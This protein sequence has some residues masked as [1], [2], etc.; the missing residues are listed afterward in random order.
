M[1][2]LR[3]YQKTALDKLLGG[4]HYLVA[5]CG[6]GKNPISIVWAE[7]TCRKTGKT[8]I[9]VITTASKSRTT[10]H[11]DDLVNFT[12]S[13]GE[14][15]ELTVVSWNSAKRWLEQHLSEIKDYVVVFDEVH[16]A[17]GYNTGMGKVFLKITK[18]NPDWTGYTGT[19]GDNWL[20]FLPYFV[21]TGLEKNKTQYLDKYARVQ[22]F[23]G[24]PEIVG[25]RNTEVLDQHWSDISCSI[26]P[27]EVMA[28][29]KSAVHH[30]LVFKAP[31][32]YKKLLKTR[33]NSDGEFLET[34]GALVAE[35][36][37]LCFTK[38]KQEWLRDF[39][40]DTESG[41]VLFYWYV[42]TGDQLAELAQK[43]LP[44]GARVWRVDGKH[45][46]I[47]T[48]E[49]IGKHDVVIC[50]W[51]AASEALNLQF[52]HYWVGV[53]LCYSYTNFVQGLGR[54]DRIGQASKMDCYYLL[55]KDT[56]EQDVWH[57]LAN[58]GEF[59]EK[60]WYANQTG[61]TM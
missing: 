4:K 33:T 52:L 26:P 40:T 20:A 38:E 11:A 18:E 21:A 19:P 44:K 51:Q 12:E 49:T 7:M 32:T 9:L 46:E 2:S 27:E 56:I 60:T 47:P 23:K 13:K 34:A 24:F 35:A 1:L 59:S 31:A 17:K 42:N 28:D 57:T 48:A 25:W 61:G 41:S 29:R 8:K 36:R 37:R 43:T 16:R 45:K 50:Q 39:L 15:L 53:E 10:D 58:K 54:I 6:S 3:L 14:G 5:G 30:R 22:T 55:T